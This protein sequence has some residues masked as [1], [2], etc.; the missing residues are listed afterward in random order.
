MGKK[1]AQK[2]QALR[3]V[4]YI[5]A[6]GGTPIPYAHKSYHGYAIDLQRQYVELRKQCPVEVAAAARV[7]GRRLIRLHTLSQAAE[8]IL[9]GSSFAHRPAIPKSAVVSSCTAITEQSA[10]T[11]IEESALSAR[12]IRSA[13]FICRRKLRHGDFWSALMHLRRLE[14]EGVVIYPCRIC[15]GLHIGHDQEHARKRRLAKRELGRLEKRLRA[16]EEERMKLQ[17]R[18]RSLLKIIL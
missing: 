13:E 14:G 7:A 10:D 8:H 9:P 4:V 2:Q 12:E 1:G 15:D 18:E 16:L 3:C 17:D 11:D 6:L 5:H